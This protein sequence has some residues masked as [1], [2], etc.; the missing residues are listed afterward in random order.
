MTRDGSPSLESHRWGCA[1]HSRHGALTEALHVYVQE[2]LAHAAAQT[3]GPLQILEMGAGTGLNAALALDWAQQQGRELHYMGIDLALPEQEAWEAWRDSWPQRPSWMEKAQRI[4]DAWAAGQRFVEKGLSA[5]YV[6]GLA[7]EVSL[8]SGMH[9]VFY[10]AFSPTQQ[11]ELWTSDALAPWLAALHPQGY[12]VTYCARGHV[13]RAIRALGYRVEHVQGPPG[14][15]EM[16]RASVV[17]H[18]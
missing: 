17:S 14:K 2:G 16:L 4:R 8:P 1:F 6:P 18:R 7:S 11:P 5:T 10:D 3:A 15:R 13:F 12:L 9:C